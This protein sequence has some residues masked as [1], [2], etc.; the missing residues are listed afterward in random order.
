MKKVLKIDTSQAGVIRVILD[1]GGR[2]I[3]KNSEQEFGSQALMPLI[4]EILKESKV[5]KKDLTEIEVN[6]GPGSYTGLKVGVA[7]ANALG[8]VLGIPVN[9]KKIELEVRY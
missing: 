9:G 8:F 5:D 3:E 1:I 4:E 7:V 2:E 6:T